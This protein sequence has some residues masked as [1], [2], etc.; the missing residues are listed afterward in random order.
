MSPG[1][2][3]LI[4]DSD[5]RC[6]QM[7]AYHLRQEGYAIESSDTAEEALELDLPSFSLIIVDSSLKRIDGLRFTS[8]IKGAAA[9]AAIPLIIYS[10]LGD[11]DSVIAGFNAGA[12]DYIVK[13]ISPR[14][15]LA[16][17]NAML[18]RTRAS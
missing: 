7:V 13:P 1:Q 8:L 17:V 6:R 12:D 5:E 4:V 16:R 11:P 9:T 14:T 18:R 3:I 2:K 15:L 10:T